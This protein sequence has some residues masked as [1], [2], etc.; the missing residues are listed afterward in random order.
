MG[1]RLNRLVREGG[2]WM[3]A[4]RSKVRVA[5]WV[6]LLLANGLASAQFVNPTSELQSDQSEAQQSCS[7]SVYTKPQCP[8]GGTLSG[9][10]CGGCGW[11]GPTADTAYCKTTE[12]TYFGSRPGYCFTLLSQV[13]TGWVYPT[14][15]C[16]SGTTFLG[17]GAGDCVSK[18]FKNETDATAK[19]AGFGGAGT[20]AGKGRGA[21]LN[22]RTGGAFWAE[23]DF[24]GGEGV[25]S[26][27][28]YYN[29]TV[30]HDISGM[31]YGWTHSHFMRLN[32]R[33]R[34]E[35]RALRPDGS[36][37]PFTQCDN[38]GDCG[39]DADVDLALSH[40]S[41]GTYKLVRRDG[42]V[43]RRQLS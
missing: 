10:T 24:A 34:G 7:E 3:G 16:P 38:V 4:L 15:P 21:V 8:E 41:D 14:T 6:A 18:D 17:S 1:E 23:N 39:S 27:T 32:I 43:A 25:P 5:S 37:V 42:T 19:Y 40:N 9:S 33:N 29:S 31:G 13:T 22:L 20:Y 35:I 30:L 12:K 26:L 28:R 11:P 36:S 2:T